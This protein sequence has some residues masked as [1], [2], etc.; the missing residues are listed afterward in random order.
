[1]ES[2]QTHTSKRAKAFG[3]CEVENFAPQPTYTPA[4]RG[5]RGLCEDGQLFDKRT[6]H[7][8]RMTANICDHTTLDRNS[9]LIDNNMFISTLNREYQQQLTKKSHELQG[10]TFPSYNKRKY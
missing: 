5:K 3:S 9:A 10:K 2:P 7:S 1:M 6:R 4:A 8:D